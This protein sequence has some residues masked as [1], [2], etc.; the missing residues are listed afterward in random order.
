LLFLHS[1]P[2][3]KIRVGS[4][5]TVGDTV[6]LTVSDDDLTRYHPLIAD[7]EPD[8]YFQLSEEFKL[9]SNQILKRDVAILNLPDF[10]R[11]FSTER[12]RLKNDEEWRF[13]ASVIRRVH[14]DSEWMSSG[15]YEIRRIEDH[16]DEIAPTDDINRTPDFA[17]GG[18]SKQERDLFHQQMHAYREHALRTAP[19]NR[20]TLKLMVNA[21]YERLG[22]VPPRVVILPNPLS[23]AIAGA[24]ATLMLFK[25]KHKVYKTDSPKKLTQSGLISRAVFAATSLQA[26]YGALDSIDSVTSRELNEVTSQSSGTPR[27]ADDCIRFFQ[28]RELAQSVNNFRPLVGAGIDSIIEQF[29]GQFEFTDPN[30][31]I[32]M[33]QI[34]DAIN[35]VLSDK[36]AFATT[37]GADTIDNAIESL[38]SHYGGDDSLVRNAMNTALNDRR[39][40]IV[41]AVVNPVVVFCKNV[42]K[43]R[44]PA[45]ETYEIWERLVLEGAAFVMHEEFC[46][47]SDFPERLE[48]DD[49]NRLHSTEGP[50]IK[51]RDGWSVYYW[52]GTPVPAKI[53]ESPELITI[54][55]INYEHNQEVRRV[56]IERYGAGR[57]ILDSDAEEVQQDEYGILYRQHLPNDEPVTIVR[58]K[59]STPEPDGS[60]KEYFLRVP[61][62]TETAKEGVAWTFGLESNDYKP[63]IES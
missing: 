48:F 57:Y 54:E 52:H 30:W 6:Y 53:I 41:E 16:V 37:A 18:I 46:F 44:V 2:I 55:S 24:V 10:L 35:Y 4:F 19:V 3:N 29:E 60:I 26:A 47:V 5:T 59:N 13:R 42:L 1:K 50:A 15:V 8:L 58:V 12:E 9:S 27:F 7:L 28:S 17:S 32:G 23:A 40:L 36:T 51:W 21:F 61:P 49:R 39:N 56:M 11:I 22:L 34:Y 25:Q 62:D 33:Q 43:L 38:V 63:D 20:D 45:F 31:Q 14:Q